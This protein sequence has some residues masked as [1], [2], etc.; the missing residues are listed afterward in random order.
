M[1]STNLVVF[2]DTR[3]PLASYLCAF[4]YVVAFWYAFVFTS[5]KLRKLRIEHVDLLPAELADLRRGTDEVV[6]QLFD[7]VTRVRAG[8]TDVFRGLK[9]EINDLHADDDKFVVE[10]REHFTRVTQKNEAVENLVTAAIVRTRTLEAE[11]DLLPAQLAGLRRGIHEVVTQLHDEVARVQGANSEVHRELRRELI[12][13]HQ[14]NGKIVAELREHVTR[15]S[16]QND[17]ASVKMRALEAELD[18]QRQKHVELSDFARRAYIPPHAAVVATAAKEERTRGNAAVMAEVVRLSRD[19][20]ACTVNALNEVVIVDHSIMEEPNYFEGGRHSSVATVHPSLY[21]QVV[22]HNQF[23]KC[24]TCS[25]GAALKFFAF[26]GWQEHLDDALNF[27]CG[28]ADCPREAFVLYCLFLKRFELRRSDPEV[29]TFAYLISGIN[30]ALNYQNFFIHHVFRSAVDQKVQDV[31][32]Y[33]AFKLNPPYGVGDVSL[34][35]E[36]TR[37]LRAEQ[38]INFIK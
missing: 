27:I 37:T 28:I 6:T 25:I 1:L 7:E 32:K 12:E 36:N 15:L 38:P 10:L 17:A 24:P 8:N 20:T 22:S 21:H 29:Y 34:N 33:L 35:P 14:G 4:A 13:R 16:Q 3:T 5:G 31:F 30:S 18:T 2:D 11:L 23:E 19:F 26:Y 9:E